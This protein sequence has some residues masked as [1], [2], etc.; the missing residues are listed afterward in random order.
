MYVL[1]IL[2]STT[3]MKKQNP[4]IFQCCYN[5]V[6]ILLQNCFNIILFFF[7][8]KGQKYHD[9]DTFDLRIN[10][11]GTLINLSVPLLYH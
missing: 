8:K 11:T 3:R 5:I 9:Y 1:C 4:I 7:Y 6:F 2:I 10:F